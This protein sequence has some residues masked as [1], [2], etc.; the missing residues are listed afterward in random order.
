MSRI[1]CG[2]TL[3]ELM[4]V[5]GLIALIMSFAAYTINKQL[6]GQQ[7]RS[8]AKELAAE[9]R[10]TKSQA[11]VTGEAQSFQI[12][13]KTREWKGPKNHSGVLPKSLEVIATT[14]RVEQPEDDVAAIKFFP[15]G[16]ATGGRIVLQ[17][18]TASWYKIKLRHT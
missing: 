17:H 8:S 12:N 18:D 7:L 5:M 15:D 11:M 3:I 9:L 6:P 16:A 13:A 14:A 10:F 1:A 2:F 4:V